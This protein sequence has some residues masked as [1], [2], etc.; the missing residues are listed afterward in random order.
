MNTV[1]KRDPDLDTKEDYIRKTA[2]NIFWEIRFSLKPDAIIAGRRWLRLA[3]IWALRHGRAC[4]AGEL[5]HMLDRA[6]PPKKAEPL[7]ALPMGKTL[8]ALPAGE[9]EMAA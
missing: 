3:I 2:F 4:F 6:F 9:M 7:L 8:L 1:S 5:K